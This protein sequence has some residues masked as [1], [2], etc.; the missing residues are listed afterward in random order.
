MAYNEKEA[1]ELV[2]EAGKRLLENGLIARTWGNVSA[3][4]SDT[5]F[6]ITPSGKPYD[7]LTPEELVIVNIADCSYDGNIKPSSEKGIHADAYKHRANVNFIIHT[8]Q[9]R[10]SVVGATGKPITNVPEKYRETLGTHIPVADYGM[11][12]TGK[13]RKALEQVYINF[14][15]SKAFL[16]EHHGAVCLGDDYDEAF[17]I[18]ETLE[19]LCKDVIHRAYRV[20]EGTADYS[21]KAMIE[22]FIRANGVGQ[23]PK[24]VTDFG[25]S[26]KNAD[27]RTFTVKY[28]NGNEFV[29][30][31]KTCTSDSEKELPRTAMVHA[32]IYRNSDITCIKHCTEINVVGYSV[33]GSPIHPRLDDFAQIAGVKI[34]NIPWNGSQNCARQIAI[35]SRGKNVILIKGLGA[36]L[37]GK[38]KSDLEAVELVLSKECQTQIGSTFFGAGYPLSAVDCNIMRT[39]YITKY[40]KKAE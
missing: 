1:R 4:I 11:P 5:Q 6:V 29:V 9:V 3:R 36:I 34:K 18:A 19:E 40:S 12:S 13:L 22:S 21:R 15:D 31:I 38:K 37:T 35:A 20:F 7:T 30:D 23:F 14:K 2:I 39:I 10:A 25:E 16:M 28:K 8:H 32:E 27:G 33:L 17:L 26:E 24:F